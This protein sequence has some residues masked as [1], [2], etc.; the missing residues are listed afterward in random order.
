M[1]K[2]VVKVWSDGEKINKSKRRDEISR[3]YLGELETDII[4]KSQSNDLLKSSL[5]KSTVSER[6]SNRDMMGN[7]NRNP[8]MIGN[9]YLEDLKVQDTF[10]RPKISGFEDPKKE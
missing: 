7:I 2:Y 6:I 3:F 9:N 5:K 1:S 4:M 10:L 8:Y